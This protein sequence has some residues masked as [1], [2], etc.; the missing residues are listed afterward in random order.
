MV[1]ESCIIMSNGNCK[2]QK[3]GVRCGVLCDRIGKEFE[4]YG[5]RRLD[6]KMSCRNII[7]NS[8]EADIMSN[9]EKLAKMNPDTVMI[10][11]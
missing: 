2:N 1:L 7:Y 6:G 8:V 5:E 9:K 4:I 11:L 3:T 10:M